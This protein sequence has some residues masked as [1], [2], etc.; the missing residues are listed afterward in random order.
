[1]SYCNLHYSAQC[2]CPGYP[3]MASVLRDCGNPCWARPH[4]LRCLRYQAADTI[5]RLEQRVERFLERI[6]ELQEEAER[7]TPMVGYINIP[8]PIAVAEQII[9]TDRILF[10]LEHFR[11][12]INETLN[13]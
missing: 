8:I 3:T 6:V 9:E 13:G 1:M 7:N 12:A 4:T 2:G 10:A 5:E 11:A